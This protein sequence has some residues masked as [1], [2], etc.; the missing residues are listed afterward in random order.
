MNISRKKFVLLFLVS[1]FVF[2]F[3]SNALFGTDA[4]VFPQPPESWLGTDPQTGWKS[5]GYKILL[6]IKMMLIGPMLTTGN[7]LREDPPPPFVA[8]VFILYWS[9]LAL[10]IHYLLG[11]RKRS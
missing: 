4:R 2:M 5:A 7:F 6:P 8:A 10:A 9:V 11:K 1:A 3:I